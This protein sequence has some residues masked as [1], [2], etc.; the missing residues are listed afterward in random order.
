MHI[1][2]NLGFT[3]LWIDASCIRQYREDEPT[4]HMDMMNII[5]SSA[6]ITIVSNTDSVDTGIPGIGHPRK[7]SQIIYTGRNVKFISTMQ[8]FAQALIGSP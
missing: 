8:T 4:P 7:G 1:A 3:F 6:S 2:E 5:Y